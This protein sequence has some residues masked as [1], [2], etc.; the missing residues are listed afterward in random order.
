MKEERSKN[1][2]SREKNYF[3]KGDSRKLVGRPSVL[4]LGVED[5]N[6][7]NKNDI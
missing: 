6:G 4:V 1:Q 2:G 5:V 3:K 7:M